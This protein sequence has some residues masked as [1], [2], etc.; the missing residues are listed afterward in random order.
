[1]P[2]DLKWHPHHHH[3]LLHILP[4]ALSRFEAYLHWDFSFQLPS[5]LSFLSLLF[6]PGMWLTSLSACLKGGDFPSFWS[7]FSSSRKLQDFQFVCA[8]D[9]LLNSDKLSLSF[10][11]SS[12][13][14]SFINKRTLTSLELY[15][16]STRT[17]PDFQQHFFLAF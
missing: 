2:V 4:R 16:G 12:F 7:P 6:L 1:M 8:G 5:A 3:L 10:N 15:G 11:L 17:P 13:S 14:G 9:F